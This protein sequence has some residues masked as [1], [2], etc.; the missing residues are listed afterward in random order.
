MGTLSSPDPC[1]GGFPVAPGVT[2]GE[3]VALVPHPAGII[4]TRDMIE[5]L[6][7]SIPD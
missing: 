4:V 1:S 5:D 7:A 2:V 3:V 6:S